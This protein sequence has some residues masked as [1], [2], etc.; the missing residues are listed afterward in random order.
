MRGC[1][2]RA[3]L[4]HFGSPEAAERIGAWVA[5]DDSFETYEEVVERCPPERIG[6]TPGAHVAIIGPL[7]GEFE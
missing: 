1:D 6:L 4:Q 5:D 2:I 7:F 3:A